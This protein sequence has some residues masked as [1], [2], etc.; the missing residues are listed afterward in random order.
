MTV[1][2]FTNHQILSDEINPPNE[3]YLST[4]IKGLKSCYALSNEEL[5]TYFS[6]TLG[7]KGFVVEEGLDR[8]I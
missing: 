7:I 3:A 2:R 1:F 4:I 6:E 5:K 8:L